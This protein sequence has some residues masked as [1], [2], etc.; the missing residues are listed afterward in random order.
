MNKLHNTPHVGYSKVFFGHCYV[1]NAGPKPLS[2][3]AVFFGWLGCPS[4]AMWC[5]MRFVH[6]S[7]PLLN[8]QI[9][10]FHTHISGLCDLSA[11][12]Y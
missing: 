8:Q 2:P 1:Q 6:A 12:S 9:Q 5:V 10:I 7:C 3:P 4:R 11:A